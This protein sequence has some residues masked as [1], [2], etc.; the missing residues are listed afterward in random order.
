MPR[1]DLSP[2]R[3]PWAGGWFRAR[4]TLALVLAL[5]AAPLGVE[6]A[7]LPGMGAGGARDAPIASG[8]VRHPGPSAPAIASVD[9]AL[10]PGRSPGS[11][12]GAPAVEGAPGPPTSDRD[13]PQ[14]PAPSVRPTQGRGPPPPGSPAFRMMDAP[15]S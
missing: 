2:R 8:N 12:S 6:A 13:A 11:F 7:F 14:A 3:R 10:A 9:P 15:H 4:L 5:I 1:P